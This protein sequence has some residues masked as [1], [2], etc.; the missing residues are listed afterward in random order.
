MPLVVQ[1]ARVED[2]ENIRALM[3]RVIESAVVAAHRNDIVEN[4]ESSVAV[5]LA[6]PSACVHRVAKLNGSIIGVVLVKDFW[7][8]CSL[9]VEQSQQNSG[10]GTLLVKAAIAACEDRSPR[11]ALFL[12]AYPS[13][14]GFYERLGFK[15][16]DSATKQSPPGVQPMKLGL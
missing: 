14:V 12:N 9:F 15:F 2:A 1:P 5:W 11:K 4:V 10:V 16:I 6:R 13:A 8:L 3:R 7:N